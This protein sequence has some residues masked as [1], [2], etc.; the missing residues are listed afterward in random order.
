MEKYGYSRG[1]VSKALTSAITLWL[2]HDYESTDE[3]EANNR[4][5]ESL[6]NQLEANHHGQ[7]AVIA[8]GKL[9]S[10]HPSLDEALKVTEGAA[11]THRIICKIGEK[12][13]P[14]VRLGWRTTRR[15]GHT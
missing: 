8:A 11:S 13:I 6:L 2:R 10:T 15:A 14:K 1:A 12:P 3:E 7:Y 4:A 5:F 9:A